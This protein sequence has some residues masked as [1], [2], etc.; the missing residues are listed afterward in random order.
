MKTH[1]AEMVD[2]ARADAGRLID[3]ATRLEQDAL[4]AEQ[5]GNG[6]PAYLKAAAADCRAKADEL[7]DKARALAD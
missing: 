1:N 2:E 5:D 7:I 6:D 4:L 3:E